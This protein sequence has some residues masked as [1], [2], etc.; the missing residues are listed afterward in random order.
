[1][2]QATVSPKIAKKTYGND[3]EH[4]CFLALLD[5]EGYTKIGWETAQ[6]L[7]R[8]KHRSSVDFA[9]ILIPVLVRVVLMVRGS[10][11]EPLFEFVDIP[12]RLE[13]DRLVALSS[14]N[15]FR[16]HRR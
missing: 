1:L 6:V 11:L 10:K 15:D 7:S 13:C 8:L 16:F 5:P 14:G 3:P 12:L 2:R 4:S 9:D